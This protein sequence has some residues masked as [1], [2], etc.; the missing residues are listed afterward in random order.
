MTKYIMSEISI[1]RLLADI[2][3]FLTEN[4]E[5]SAEGFGWRAIKETSLV[6]RLREGGDVSTRKMDAIIVFMAIYRHK[7]GTDNAEKK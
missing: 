3:M 5:L 4:P 2:E 1:V 7:K 6:K